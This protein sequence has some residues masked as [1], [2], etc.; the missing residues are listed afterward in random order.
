MSDA[1]HTR[2]LAAIL[3]AE[4]ASATEAVQSAVKVQSAMQARQQLKHKSR[5]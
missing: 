3:V 2:K 4:F 1:G 5:E